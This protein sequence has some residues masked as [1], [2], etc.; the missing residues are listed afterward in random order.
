MSI[1]QKL[2]L[3]TTILI[4]TLLT[5]GLTIIY[6][7]NYVTDK[8]S[9]SNDF[10]KQSMYLQTMLRGINEI[11]INDGTPASIAIAKE[12]FYGFDEIHNRLMTTVKEPAIMME[13]SKH[14]DPHWQIIKE[15]IDPFFDHYLDLEDDSSLIKA[16]MLIA[17]AEEIIKHVKR[18]AEKTRDVVNKNSVQSSIVGKAI[19]IVFVILVLASFFLSY[20][21]YKA[22]TRP[23]EE[24]TSIAEGFNRGDL[25]ILMDESRNNE[26][27]KLAMHFNRSTSKLNQT[28]KILKGRTKE[29]QDSTEELL[30]TNN[31]LT[32]EIAERKLAEKRISHLAYHDS[33]TDLPNR[34]L[35]QDRLSMS[36]A[37]TKNRQKKLAVLFLDIDDFKRINDTFGHS[38]GDLL[39]KEIVDKIK[40]CIRVTD[41]AS[42]QAQLDTNHVTAARFGG[43]EF[44]I[45][46]PDIQGPG[47]AVRVVR[48]L[49]A[50]LARPIRL[51][52]SEVF[53]TMSVGISISPDDGT[54]AEQILKNADTALYHAKEAGKNTFK[55][56]QGFMNGIIRKHLRIERGLRKAID[57]NEMLVY[58]Q[59][60]ID[61]KTG[62]IVSMEALSRWRQTD[63][64]IVPPG[65]FIPVAEDTGL[66][67][68]LG[69]WI[70]RT[71]CTQNKAW[72]I[73]GHPPVSI[74]VNISAKQF[75]HERFLQTI[76]DALTYS[77]LDPQYLELE[78][79]ENIL[80]KYAKKTIN[81]LRKLKDM[82]I[83][84]A[85]DD[86]GTGYS[87]FNYL[88][89]F[90]LDVVKIDISFIEN[91]TDKPDHAAIVKAI[92]S[93]AHSL[94]LKV[95]AEG[96]ETV[97]QLDILRE[98]GCDEIQGFL[99]SRPVTAEEFIK[100]FKR[101]THRSLGTTL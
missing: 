64:K 99:Y 5:L 23:I 49:F 31:K 62:D 100:L 53:I 88:I 21:L 94:N 18:L 71:A 65:E 17:E 70:L 40:S 25:N 63:K 76:T 14:C 50:A 6:G 45:L 61:V 79:T 41:S 51:A 3:S 54:D 52:T 11:L 87:S 13:I 15:N 33:L 77:S 98:F 60:R 57:R 56:Y 72:Q 29:L 58:Y 66:I 12:G 20:H 78:I 24:L 96:V 39:L 93:M 47:D 35:F 30:K 38:T 8:A 19:I 75:L 27:G 36:I 44:I 55:F 37:N 68:P 92:I 86:F 97:Q 80:M 42:R 32:D 16:G 4:V 46:L 9:L 73:S 81:I 22:I 69:E 82:G 2:I 95:V 26:F 48:R 7:Y 101:S 89:R 34:Y 28:T 1:K 67:I 83:R 85:M 91:I 43:D 59:P 74:S 10:D 84:L 90:P